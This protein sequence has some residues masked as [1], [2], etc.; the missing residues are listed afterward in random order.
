[1]ADTLAISTGDILS[2]MLRRLPPSLWDTDP[3]ADTLQRDLFAAIASQTAVW[4]EQRDIARTMTLMLQAEGIDLD[5]LLQDYGL[6]RYLQLPDPYAARS[7][8]T[9]CGPRRARGIAS[10]GWPISS[11]TTSRMSPCVRAATSSTSLWRRRS[12]SRLPTATGAW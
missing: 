7:G 9:S 8:C 6:K 11:C 10:P 2:R 4:L 3:S 1:M 5:V 12:P